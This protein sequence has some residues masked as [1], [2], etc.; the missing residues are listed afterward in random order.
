MIDQL[1]QIVQQ[2]A[3]QSVVQNN[4]VPNQYN[5]GVMQEA[6]NNIFSGLQNMLSHG[7][8]SQLSSLFNDNRDSPMANQI[9]GNFINS[10]TE[11]FGIDKNAAAGI[12]SSL[13]P[14]VLSSLK[15][16]VNDPN[17]SSINLE[18]IISSLQSGG[19]ISDT[20]NSIGS[21][22]GL[23]KDKDGDVDLSDIAGMFGK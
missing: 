23:D 4:D 20:I 5:E 9:S 2:N 3:Q 1:M 10:I 16:K 14:Q 12:A 18:G 13:I 7:G 22:F 21:K 11:K 6:G 8:A 19:N 15:G 17:D